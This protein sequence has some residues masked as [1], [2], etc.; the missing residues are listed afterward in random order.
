MSMPTGYKPSPLGYGSPRSS[1]F[2]RPES[3]A[4]PSTLRQT[5]PRASP[6]K[7]EHATGG[8]KFTTGPANTP[9]SESWP[10]RPSVSSEPPQPRPL[11]RSPGQKTM[12]NGGGNALAQ[13]QPAQVRTLRDGF[14][15]LDRDSDGVVNREDV[16]D[17]LTQLGL[18]ANPSDVSPFFP[19]AAAQT[20]TLAV[21]LN[22]LATS[23]T[24]LS[25][26]SELLSA[27]SAFDDD[28]SGQID[29]A[30]LRDALLHTAPDP[31]ERALTGSEID[32]IMDGF[33]GRRAF[34]KSKASNLGKRGEVFRYQD[35]VT[36][37]AGG[38]NAADRGSEDDEDA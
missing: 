36:S 18:P 22:S 9:T 7:P 10:P 15:I 6:A 19:P 32:K 17:M 1:P 16:A 33:S 26:S 11:P 3:P 20:M 29:V 23:L 21:F 25:P 8:A 37:V 27:F 34:T 35:F 28:D 14:Q 2:R 4:S 12:A 5:T 31:G 30:E 13:L 24:A 38:N